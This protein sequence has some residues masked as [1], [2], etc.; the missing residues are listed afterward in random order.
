[1]QL[2]DEVPQIHI[3]F[4]QEVLQLQLHCRLDCGGAV[5]SNDHKQ[6][7]QIA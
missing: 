2:E 1:M 3:S 7:P 6:N 4:D 5:K